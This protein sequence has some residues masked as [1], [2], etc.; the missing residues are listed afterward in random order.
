MPDHKTAV[1]VLHDPFDYDAEDA[2]IDAYIKGDWQ[3]MKDIKWKHEPGYSIMGT[4][5]TPNI[6]YLYV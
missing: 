2:L 5:S 1:N 3:A 6:L 4:F